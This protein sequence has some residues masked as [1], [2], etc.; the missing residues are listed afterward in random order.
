MNI[1]RFRMHKN[2]QVILSLLFYQASHEGRI[3]SLRKLQNSRRVTGFASGVSRPLLL[4]VGNNG[5]IF[6]CS[7]VPGKNKT[8]IA[9]CHE[10]RGKHHDLRT[11]TRGLFVQSKS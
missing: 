2:Q 10:L 1:W 5:F 8:I 4:A 3:Y 9:S 11:T 7:H 6:P